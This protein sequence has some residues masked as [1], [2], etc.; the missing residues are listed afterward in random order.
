ML[1]LLALLHESAVPHSHTEPAIAAA[2]AA[3]IPPTA[4]LVYRRKRQ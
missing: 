4:A 2:I 3:M 1:F